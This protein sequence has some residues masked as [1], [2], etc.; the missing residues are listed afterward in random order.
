RRARITASR[1]FSRGPRRKSNP[2]QFFQ[3]KEEQIMVEPTTD[4]Q[5]KARDAQ[6]SRVVTVL[7]SHDGLKPHE[8]DDFGRYL[9]NVFHEAEQVSVL[10]RMLV[11]LETRVKVLE[12]KK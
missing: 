10:R 12:P 4:E 5:K 8:R 3:G 2:S 6:R 7:T 11:A 1:R 9:W